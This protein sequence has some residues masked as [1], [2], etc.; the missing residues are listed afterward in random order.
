MN[1]VRQLSSAE[2][3][4]VPSQCTSRTF[5]SPYVFINDLVIYNINNLNIIIMATNAYIEFI[6]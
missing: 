6:M 3:T 4:L 1:I 5:Q 2:K